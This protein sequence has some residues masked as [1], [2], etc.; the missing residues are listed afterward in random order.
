MKIPFAAVYLAVKRAG[1]SDRVISGVLSLTWIWVGAAYHITYFSSINKAAYL[2]GALFIVQGLIFLAYG[3]LRHGIEFRQGSASYRFA[4]WALILY[5]MLVYPVLGYFQGHWFPQS[6]VFGV[7]PCPVTIFT[8]GLLLL[9]EKAPRPMVVIPFLWSVVGFSAALTMGIR[10]DIGLLVAGLAGTV[11]IA[12]QPR[13]H[14]IN[15]KTR[16]QSA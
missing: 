14:G 8:F 15:P 4:G 3:V 5:A 12:F 13:M 1:Y 10:E 9:A 2:F 6:P 11:M 7:A 16:N